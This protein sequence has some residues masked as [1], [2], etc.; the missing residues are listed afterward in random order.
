MA[1]VTVSGLSMEFGEQKLFEGMNFEIQD[2]ERIGLIGVNGCGK[3]TLFKLLAGEYYPT[4]GTIA[5][6]KNTNIG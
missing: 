3:T 5:I 1:I 6:N 4:G 2:N